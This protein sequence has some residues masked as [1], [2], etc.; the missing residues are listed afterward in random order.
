M[1]RKP[2]QTRSKATVDAI[3]QATFI[4]VAERGMNDTTTR[5][6]AELAGVSVG[7]LYEYFANK[8]AL[9]DAVAERFVDDVVAMLK[10]LQPTL[11]KLPIDKAVYTL[12]MQFGDLLQRNNALYLKCARE[13]IQ[14]QFQAHLDK[15]NK[16]LMDLVIQYGLHNPQTLNIG[17]LPT[18]S[19]IFINGGIFAVVRHLSDS[20]PPMTFEELARGLSDMVGHYVAMEL[21]KKSAD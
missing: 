4:A 2:Q 12:L 1:P 13:A 10:P 19:Y 9:F 3:I 8:E 20:N 16:V 15:F 14:T 6:V 11:V 5:Y 7:S 18:M 21:A 17:N